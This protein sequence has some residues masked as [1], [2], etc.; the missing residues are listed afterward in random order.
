MRKVSQHQ[1]HQHSPSLVILCISVTSS[2][3]ML[4]PSPSAPVSSCHQIGWNSCESQLCVSATTKFDRYVSL[5]AEERIGFFG[6]WLGYVLYNCLQNTKCF[7]WFVS[8]PITSLLICLH[9]CL[10][11]VCFVKTLESLA[12][13][14][15]EKEKGR[16]WEKVNVWRVLNWRT[17]SLSD[18]GAYIIH[19]Y[20]PLMFEPSL[21]QPV[22]YKS[23]HHLENPGA[24]NEQNKW[25]QLRFHYSSKVRALEK[26]NVWNITAEC[27]NKNI[28]PFLR[29][30]QNTYLKAA[31]AKCDGKDIF[32]PSDFISL[33]IKP[34]TGDESDLNG[35]LKVCW[36]T[37]SSDNVKW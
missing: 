9:F 4:I 3:S 33:K 23:C 30:P 16:M 32:P 6:G 22:K 27:R 14:H 7:K 19:I 15:R 24:D 36:L 34:V 29:L 12:P 10:S 13:I 2:S 37:W 20:S 31:M 1:P 21:V 17:N 26:K 8:S 5:F 35:P 18:A 11:T 25:G 28:S